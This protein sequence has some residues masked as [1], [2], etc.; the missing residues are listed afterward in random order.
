MRFLRALRSHGAEHIHFARAM[1]MTK[2]QSKVLKVFVDDMR[3]VG[4]EDKIGKKDRDTAFAIAREW[5]DNYE[6]G[7]GL[8]EKAKEAVKMPDE[9]KIAK[10]MKTLEDAVGAGMQVIQPGD[11]QYY[12]ALHVLRC[13][14]IEPAIENRDDGSNGGFK[15]FW[16]GVQEWGETAEKL[17]V[18]EGEEEGTRMICDR[19]RRG[20]MENA[21]ENRG[22]GECRDWKR[23]DLRA[24]FDA[25]VE[26]EKKEVRE[27]WR[28]KWEEL[29]GGENKRASRKNQAEAAQDGCEEGKKEDKDT[30]GEG[31][32][33][34][35]RFS[36]RRKTTAENFK[37]I[38]ARVQEA[39]N[40]FGEVTIEEICYQLEKRGHRLTPVAREFWKGCNFLTKANMEIADKL[41]VWANTMLGEGAHNGAAPKLSPKKRGRKGGVLG[42]G[43]PEKRRREEEVEEEEEA[44]EDEEEPVKMATKATLGKKKKEQKV[45]VVE[46]SKKSKPKSKPKTRAKASKSKTLLPTPPTEVVV[47][48]RNVKKPDIFDPTVTAT[49]AARK[50]RISSR[51]RSRKE[52]EDEVWED[53]EEDWEEERYEGEDEDEVEEDDGEE[54]VPH[55]MFEPKFFKAAFTPLRTVK[56]SRIEPSQS[57][58]A[59]YDSEEEKE[60]A[61]EMKMYKKS[62]NVRKVLAL[63][64]RKEVE[65]H[66]EECERI[67]ANELFFG[68]NMTDKE[69]KEKKKRDDQTRKF[70][71]TKIT[72]GN[73]AG[74][75]TRKCKDLSCRFC[76]KYF[77]SELNVFDC[78]VECAAA[79]PT[80]VEIEVD[81]SNISRKRKLAEAQFAVMYN[82]G[83][84]G[85]NEALLSQWE[86]SESDFDS[87]KEEEGG[88]E[89]GE[90]GW[91]DENTQ[92]QRPSAPM[93]LI[94]MKSPGAL[95][96][97]KKR[98]RVT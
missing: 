84:L 53:D 98:R 50:V 83:M 47:G 34:T 87:D 25:G 1:K 35:K 32:P 85:K 52:K 7:E 56:L 33:E 44:E 39:M 6:I 76:N 51:K 69:K 31:S 72:M 80:V 91:A 60:V 90:G 67:E 65:E 55:R 89:E 82:R 61:M 5:T 28:G 81:R 42:A 10:A 79:M 70:K 64:E 74:S 40:L 48:K 78:E 63:R 30:K 3:M 2:Q 62:L 95:L 57:Q 73:F 46:S 68:S 92:T 11:A 13:G 23:R 66:K 54:Y 36:S 8:K 16:N 71:E 17:G 14:K 77:A 19:E 15:V 9:G 59:F 58:N 21:N 27:Y 49:K 38:R 37:A 41:K 4:S 97:G 18:V 26:W 94:P 88:A 75:Q 93:S 24:I 45:K 86:E 96:S 22:F 20:I 12:L 29:V 43:K